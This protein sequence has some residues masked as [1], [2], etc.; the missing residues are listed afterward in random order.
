MVGLN[1]DYLLCTVDANRGE[2][3]GMVHEHLVVAHAL[4]IPAIICLTKC[5]VADE[6]RRYAALLD[7]KRYMKQLGSKNT[8]CERRQ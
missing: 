3:R 6:E 1:P 2:M 8:C 4:G 5:D 7:V